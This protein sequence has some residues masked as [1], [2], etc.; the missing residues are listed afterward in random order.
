MAVAPCRSVKSNL[1]PNSTSVVKRLFYDIE[2]A[3]NLVWSWRIGFNINLSHDNIVKERRIICIAYKWEGSDRVYSLRWDKNQDDREMLTNFL[4]IANE[5]DEL[6]AHYGDGFDLPWIRARCLIHGLEPLPLYKTVD[7]K[8]WASKYFYF[9]CNKLDY[10]SKVFGFDGK[11]ETD[12]KLW[13][14]VLAG[15]KSALDYMCKYCRDDVARLQEVWNKLRFAV[16]P[17]THVGV[18]GG[19]ERWHCAHCGSKNVRLSKKR[20]TA[21]GTIQYQM[22]CMDCGGYFQV[23]GTA[24]ENFLKETTKAKKR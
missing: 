20:V 24:Y 11:T 5:A 6:I 7:T 17:K 18:F 8:A 1:M 15:K 12:Y 4:I 10:L 22:Q 3:P 9:N 19:G 2:T 16:R 21:S 23:N 14:D 13:L